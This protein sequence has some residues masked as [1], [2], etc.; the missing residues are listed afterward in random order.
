MK[1]ID[2]EGGAVQV[3][4]DA[5]NGRGGA[6]SRDDVIV[7]APTNMLFSPRSVL[8]RVP[9][10]GG[11][12]EPVTHLLPG[13]RNHRF[14]Q[15]L[16]DGRRFLFLSLGGAAGGIYVG[17]L[18]GGEAVKVTSD[19]AAAEFAPPGALLVVRQGTLLALPF[20]HER[21]VINGTPIPVIASVASN[22]GAGRDGFTVSANGVLAHRAE[23]AQR[24]QLV[25]VDRA[26]V[27]Q[28]TVHASDE[29]QLADPELAPDG[30]NVV[31]SRTI[32]GNAD[33]WSIDLRRG[34]ANRLTFGAT[35]DTMPLWSPD[36][37]RVVFSCRSCR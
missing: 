14:P 7:F 18:D 28:G 20:D 25:W 10:S 35:S 24:R 33:I 3:L 11:S 15:F 16:P 6:W 12:S 29:N 21:A 22:F 37:S 27:V 36:G 30:Q 8:M 2:L 31:V 9:A 34:A 17:S 5:P 13:E 4:A 19:S 32:Q 23:W 1:R 26:G